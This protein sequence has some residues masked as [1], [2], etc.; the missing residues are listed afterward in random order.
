MSHLD[1]TLLNE[2]LDDAM[3]A[4]ARR[5]VEAHLQGCAD[6]RSRLDDLRFVF[7]SLAALPEEAPA[8]E[9]VASI[10]ARLPRRRLGDIWR[11]AFA[12]QTVAALAALLWLAPTFGK[13]SGRPSLGAMVE[14]AIPQIPALHL[15]QILNVELPAIAFPPLSLDLAPPTFS[16]STFNPSAFSLSTFKPIIL[17]ASAFLLWVIG[18]AV[19]LRGRPEV[20]K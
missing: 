8:R 14:F 4:A 1:E 11:L 2:Y 17:A 19:L 18:N 15:D 9:L 5:D 7:S 10:L 3:P 16:L 12:A 20:Q 13:N 6:C